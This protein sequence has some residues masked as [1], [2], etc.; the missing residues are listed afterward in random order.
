M[1]P[2][3]EPYTIEKFPATFRGQPVDLF[4]IRF[5]DPSRDPE[6]ID[7]VRAGKKF[8]DVAYNPFR[9]EE[10]AI[11]FLADL[12]GAGNE[13]GTLAFV[14]SPQNLKL[15]IAINTILRR[16]YKIIGYLVSSEG[17]Y[18]TADACFPSGKVPIAEVIKAA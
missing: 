16:T 3:K 8:P 15:I 4:E 13:G 11:K 7:A 6:V 2:H 18:A 12:A 17:V 1:D 9:N 5:Y 10:V 14:D